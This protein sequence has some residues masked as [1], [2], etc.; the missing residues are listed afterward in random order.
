ME[1]KSFKGHT[2]M[3]EF[4]VFWWDPGSVLDGDRFLGY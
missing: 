1:V 2:R 3:D 4:G